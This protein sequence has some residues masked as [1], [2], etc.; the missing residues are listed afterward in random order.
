MK[1]LFWVKRETV[2]VLKTYNRKFYSEPLFRSGASCQLFYR[3]LFLYRCRWAFCAAWYFGLQYL[4]WPQEKKCHFTMLAEWNPVLFTHALAHRSTP[5]SS[6]YPGVS[7]PHGCIY[8]RL[9]AVPLFFAQAITFLRITTTP[10]CG[11]SGAASLPLPTDVSL[12]A[13][14][15][16]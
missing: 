4:Q 15:R 6:V 1:K 12:P 5:R 14:A 13:T 10:A 11:Q 8:T 9:G 2:H 3:L 7:M 16:E